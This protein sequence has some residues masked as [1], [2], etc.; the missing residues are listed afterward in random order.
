MGDVLPLLNW[1]IESLHLPMLER[2]LRDPRHAPHLAA[3][4]WEV[5]IRPNKFEPIVKKHSHFLLNIT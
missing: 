1:S 4:K 3:E 2:V 5:I